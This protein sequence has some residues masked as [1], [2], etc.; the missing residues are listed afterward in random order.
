[1]TI[2]KRAQ[3]LGLRLALPALPFSLADMRGKEE[4]HIS[5]VG[6]PPGVGNSRNVEASVARTCS[7]GPQLFAV[8]RGRTADL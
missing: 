1:M 2:G 4:I 7:V 6:G 8:K 5:L 3:A